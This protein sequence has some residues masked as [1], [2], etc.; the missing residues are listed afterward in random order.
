MGKRL[1]RGWLY[2]GLGIVLAAMATACSSGLG[3]LSNLPPAPVAAYRLGPGDE[4]RVMVPGLAA[5][6]AMNTTYVINDRGQLAL[7]VIGD[8]PAG[9]K[10]VPELQRSIAFELAQRKLLNAPTVSV[11]PVRLRPVYILG[12]VKSPGEYQ[13]R[14]GMSVLAA[15]SV[16]GGYTFR[17]E[18]NAVEITRMVNGKPVVGRAG[19]GD[20]I[21]PGDTVR[22]HEKWF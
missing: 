16:A 18:Q 8:L 20:M 6:D 17:A 21:Q 13:Y 22:I 9:G 11:Q 14:A 4:V 3:N 2:R 12:E 5:N 15:V 10:T 7:P 19:Q 1:Y